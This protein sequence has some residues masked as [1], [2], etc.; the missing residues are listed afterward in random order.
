MA[1]APRGGTQ[2]AGARIS[3]CEH[4]V[5]TAP[6]TARKRA[7]ATRTSS[8]SKARRSGTKEGRRSSRCGKEDQRG[9]QSGKCFARSVLKRK[10][11]ERSSL[12]PSCAGTTLK[13][14]KSGSF[15][16]HGR[17]A[18]STNLA[19][20]INRFNAVRC[21][22]SFIAGQSR[23]PAGVVCLRRLDGVAVGCGQVQ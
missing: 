9:R 16:F 1:R 6:G 7:T 11:Q 4:R 12:G 18:D 5:E 10:W 14:G 8:C 20:S 23:S 19:C 13:S 22:G 3:E 15:W 2:S 17:Y 21:R